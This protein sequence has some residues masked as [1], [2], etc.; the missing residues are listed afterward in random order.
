MISHPNCWL[1]IALAI[2]IFAGCGDDPEPTLQ[3]FE[4]EGDVCLNRFSFDDQSAIEA[5]APIEVIVE[6][7]VCLSSSCSSEPQASCQATLDAESNTITL[8]SEGSY[9]DTS[10]QAQG[11]TADCGLLHADCEIPALPE[12][13][14]TLTHGQTTYTFEVPSQPEG[15]LQ[16]DAS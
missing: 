10:A 4:D 5:E 11:C 1:P 14:Y 8:T 12:G 9:L 2:T 16:A 3:S 13:Q 6:L 15:C 7:P